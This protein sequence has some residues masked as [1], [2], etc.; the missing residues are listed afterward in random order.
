MRRDDE[1]VG[2]LPFGETGLPDGV[3]PERV[4]AALRPLLTERRIRRIEE[5]LAARTLALTVVLDRFH[6]P[7]NASAVL[8]SCEAHGVQRVH[9][10]E[11][12][13]PFAAARRATQG[14][15]R[16]LTL[17]RWRDGVECARALK[18][19]GFAVA[20][21]VQ[22]GGVPPERLDV[23]RPVALVLGREHDGIHPALLAECDLRITV[24]MSGFVESLNVSVAA[25]V[26]L[27]HLRPRFRSGLPEAVASHLRAVFHVLS[28]DRAEEILA[29][30]L[31]STVP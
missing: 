19:E 10:I 12:D 27:S 17:R 13:E 8:R 18:A 7:H 4:V 24:P 11:G 26:C 16:W 3:E 14:A 2:A 5:V 9:V 20:A 28:V 23:S 25:A 29:R 21:A 6:D 31:G 15:D 30:V 1:D 22:S